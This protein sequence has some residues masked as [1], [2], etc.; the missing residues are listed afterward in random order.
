MKKVRSLVMVEEIRLYC[1]SKPGAV[2]IKPFRTSDVNLEVPR[3]MDQGTALHELEA[4]IS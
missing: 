1:L 2:E 4:R 3:A